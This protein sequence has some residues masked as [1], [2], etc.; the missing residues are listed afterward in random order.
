M[1]H[2]ALPLR[3]KMYELCIW[4]GIII[5]IQIRQEAELKNHAAINP[6]DSMKPVTTLKMGRLKT[7]ISQEDDIILLVFLLVYSW[8]PSGLRPKVQVLL[9]CGL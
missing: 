8:S 2:Y 3:V 1:L 5:Y 4:K 6:A 7:R 9:Y